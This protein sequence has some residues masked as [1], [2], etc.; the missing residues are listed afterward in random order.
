VVGLDAARLE[1]ALALHRL[2]VQVTGFDSRHSI[3]GIGDPEVNDLAI[4]EVG[5]RMRIYPGRR[6]QVHGWGKCVVVSAGAASVTAQRL[7]VSVGCAPNRPEG[8]TELSPLYRKG[9][10]AVDL[11]KEGCPL[12]FLLFARK[13]RTVHRAQETVLPCRTIAG[14]PRT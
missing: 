3:A 14:S 11:E 6:V 8:L 9:R 2:G 13:V 1:L 7:L 4:E 5:R 10:P 12:L